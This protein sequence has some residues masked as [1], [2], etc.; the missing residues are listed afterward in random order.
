LEVEGLSEQVGLPGLDVVWVGS[1]QG[2]V[3][4][5]VL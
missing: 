1:V 3:A 4:E 5:P 2:E